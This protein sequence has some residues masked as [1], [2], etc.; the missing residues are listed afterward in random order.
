MLK[1]IHAIYEHGVLKP[2]EPIEGIEENT[3]VKVTVSTEKDVS[4][5][6]L[7]FAGVLSEEDANSMMKVVDDEFERINQDE[8][9]D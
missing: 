9:R 6:L 5:P 7:R 4:P 1:T 2:L 8:W 3:K